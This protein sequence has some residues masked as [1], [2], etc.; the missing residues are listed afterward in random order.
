[1][2]AS[3]RQ[4][5]NRFSSLE[6]EKRVVW[7]TNEDR[8][9]EYGEPNKV[10]QRSVRKKLCFSFCRDDEMNQQGYY[11]M[12]IKREIFELGYFSENLRRSYT[13]CFE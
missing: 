4:P 5:E 1:M 11:K 9:R 6:N 12:V 3:V 7:K 13:G 2:T 8:T 10:V